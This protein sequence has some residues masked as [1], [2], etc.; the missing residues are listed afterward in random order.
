MRGRKP[1][2]TTLKILH[3]NP[4]KRKLPENE[5][6][7]APGSPDCPEHL[8][9]VARLE[10]ERIVPELLRLGLLT[11]IDRAAL[12]AYCQAYSR[13]QAAEGIIATEG[14][15]TV[16][17]KT[18]CI[19]THPAVSIAKESMRLVRE[20]M[21]EFGLSPASRPRVKAIDKAKTGVPTRARA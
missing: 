13:W 4:G 2:P 5:P 17:L 19:R 21:T 7:P 8:D 6:Q 3:G 12:A 16:N 1:T 18:G 10:W 20:F 15:T 11:H 14:L 9:S